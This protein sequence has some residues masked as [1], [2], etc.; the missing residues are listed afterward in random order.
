MSEGAVVLLEYGHAK[1]ARDDDVRNRAV[2]YGRL[3]AADDSHHVRPA[4]GARAFE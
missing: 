4:G 1:R 2:E 3:C